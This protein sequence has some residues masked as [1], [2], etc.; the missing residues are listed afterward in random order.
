MPSIG[1]SV[2][3]REGRA[4]VTGL[5]QYVD[6]L[7]LPGMLFG[8]TVR[9]AVPRGLIKEIEFGPDLPWNEFTIIPA[10]DVPGVNRVTLIADD[11]PCLAA[12]R[13]NHPEE[14]VILLAHP[15]RQL[16]EHARR[17]VRID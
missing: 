8:A 2:P 17:Q 11:Q 7:E 10:A 16:L 1:R 9:S 6:D 13:I 3:R 4:K 14:P 15:N 12:D 5:A